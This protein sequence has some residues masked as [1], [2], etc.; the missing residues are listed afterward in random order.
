MGFDP[1]DISDPKRELDK[2]NFTLQREVE[3]R[4]TEIQETV[5]KGIFPLALSCAWKP[6]NYPKFDIRGL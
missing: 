3:S 4:R 2:L 1:K 5:E 6:N